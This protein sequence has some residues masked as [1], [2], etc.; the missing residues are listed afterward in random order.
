MINNAIQVVEGASSKQ[1]LVGR[2]L[3]DKIIELCSCRLQYYRTDQT[4]NHNQDSIEICSI[5]QVRTDRELLYTETDFSEF[6]CWQT[7]TDFC[8]HA[9][10]HVNN[11]TLSIMLLCQLA[12]DFIS[13]L[14]SRSN[15]ELSVEHSVIIILLSKE[16]FVFLLFAL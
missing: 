15:L 5:Q 1:S 11:V 12:G 6:M 8:S 16:M 7:F 3:R 10:L 13:T 9:D 14:S 4:C 2:A